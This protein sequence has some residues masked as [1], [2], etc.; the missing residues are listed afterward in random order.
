MN[1]QKTWV[2]FKKCDWQT[3]R[4]GKGLITVMLGNHIQHR[5]PSGMCALPSA[6]LSPSNDCTSNDPSVRLKFADDTT[7]I[8]FNRSDDKTCRQEI[9]LVTPLVWAEPTAAEVR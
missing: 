6:P 9:E 5:S 7:V 1:V 3:D 2:R 8:G 4:S